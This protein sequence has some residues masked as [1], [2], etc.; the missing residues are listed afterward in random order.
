MEWTWGSHNV[1]NSTWHASIKLWS[2]DIQSYVYVLEQPWD[3]VAKLESKQHEDEE[4]WPFAPHFFYSSH[5][6]F[7]FNYRLVSFSLPFT[8]FP[9]RLCGLNPFTWRLL[10]ILIVMSTLFEHISMFSKQL[11]WLNCLLD[12]A[13]GLFLQ[14]LCESIRLL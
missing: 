3:M 4:E 14:S 10:H 12:I 9:S 11:I 2:E 7:S 6:A 13:K 5:R 1:L 8:L